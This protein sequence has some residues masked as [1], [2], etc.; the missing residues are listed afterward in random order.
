MSKVDSQ[1]FT[2]ATPKEDV[3]RF[4]RFTP[5][6]DED[7]SLFAVLDR[8][9]AQQEHFDENLSKLPA[10]IRHHAHRY[11]IRMQGHVTFNKDTKEWYVF[12]GVYCQQAPKWF[13]IRGLD[14]LSKGL[15]REA[16]LLNDKSQAGIEG[17][18]KILSVKSSTLKGKSRKEKVELL[19]KELY[20]QL[21]AS[22]LEPEK[23][24][25]LLKDLEHLE[26]ITAQAATL[27]YEAHRILDN[28]TPITVLEQVA[29]EYGVE[30][31]NSDYDSD[32]LLKVVLNGTLDLRYLGDEGKILR[33]SRPED[34]NTMCMN[35]AYNPLATAPNVQKQLEW[36]FLQ[37]NIEEAEKE[38]ML[39]YARMMLGGTLDST[40]TKGTLLIL[41]GIA[42]SGKSILL[43]S[44]SDVL[45]SYTSTVDGTFFL[46]NPSRGKGDASPH[47]AKVVG[48]ALVLSTEIKNA[49]SSTMDEAMIKAWTGGD[50]LSYR[51]LYG[52]EHSFKPNGQLV[53]STN[54]LPRLT[55]DKSVGDR[56]R[57]AVHH[58]SRTVPPEMRRDEDSLRR[59]LLEE[60]SGFLNILL[61]GL[62]ERNAVEGRIK[63]PLSIEEYTREYVASSD[64]VQQFFDA[65][66]IRANPQDGTKGLQSTA[67]Y[68]MYVDYKGASATDLL[69]IAMFSTKLQG[70][71]YSIKHT[72][73]GNYWKGVFPAE[74]S[75]R[76]APIRRDTS[77]I[78]I[79][80][81]VVQDTTDIEAQLAEMAASL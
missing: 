31:V 29:C 35:V 56:H 8:L 4:I 72:K 39:R 1:I 54:E 59:E 66:N 55:G 41:S 77:P 68:K 61:Q 51:Q 15:A 47:M 81:T 40:R 49:A 21:T 58:C 45:G 16:A 27:L 12:N 17:I 46:D 6:T 24:P 48:K 33:T 53:M 44:F 76:Q 9:A 42:G 14:L 7:K 38:G 43:N 63:P 67:L 50:P 34:L 60:G 62:A 57:L 22:K 3:Q 74:D 5:K 20:T 13:L 75:S 10:T 36:V 26:S 70:R 73:T 52:K 37:P 2:T 64:E 23:L 28:R 30:H 25:A 71:G 80:S 79:N 18:C 32:G 11:A 65:C 69:S 19:R 78:P